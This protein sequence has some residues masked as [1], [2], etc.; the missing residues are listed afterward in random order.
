MPDIWESLKICKIAE[1]ADLEPEGRHR[2]GVARGSREKD[3]DH[4]IALASR[5][6]RPCS[7]PGDTW[8]AACR[9]TLQ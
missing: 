4:H 5:C 6:P 9:S 2:S 3:K 7:S 8:Q 1:V